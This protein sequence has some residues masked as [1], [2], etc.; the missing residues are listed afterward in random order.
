MPS[1]QAEP[2]QKH[3][4][5]LSALR[6][7]VRGEV[8]ADPVSRGM[9]ATDASHYQMMPACVVVPKDEQDVIEAVKIATANGMPI[10]A[11]GGGT[12]LAG[13]TFGTGMVLD[14]SKY[15]NNVLEVNE[16]EQWA[17]VQPGVVRDQLNKF[18]LPKACTLRPTPLPAAGQPSAG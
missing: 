4:D 18:L 9:H 16:Q 3:N 6:D 2:E 8:H 15:M 13:Q 12:S 5:A 11:R 14:C 17:R 7:K 1:T 10:T